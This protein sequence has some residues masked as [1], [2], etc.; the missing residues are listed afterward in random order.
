MNIINEPWALE[1]VPV[2]ER[3]PNSKLLYGIGVNDTG[4]TSRYIEG[5]RQQHPAYKAWTAMLK[6]SFCLKYHARCPTYVGT[7][8]ADAWLTFSG[9]YAWWLDNAVKGYQLD[10]DLLGT[11]KHYSP[12]SCVFVPQALNKLTIGSKANRGELPQGICWNKRDQKYQATLTL[13]GVS[14]NLG[15]FDDP[16]EALDA[17]WSAKWEHAPAEAAHLMTTHPQADALTDRVVEGVIR[18][19]RQQEAEAY[20]M[21]EALELSAAIGAAA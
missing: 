17:Y 21:L 9:F 1:Y 4:P 20:Q 18:I 6:R 8:V 5:K 12:A 16:R 7:T 19:L 3:H 13:Q 15:Y 14:K 2:V 11:G 10:K